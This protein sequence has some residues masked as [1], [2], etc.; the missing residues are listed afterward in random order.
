METEV[1]IS[2]QGTQ[3]DPDGGK[4]TVELLT[5]GS[6]TDDETGTYRLSYR[7]SELTGLEGT[8]T[9][10]CIGNEQ[11]AMLREG[12]LN[13][14][15]IFRTGERH[16]SLYDTDVGGFMLGVKTQYVRAEIGQ[17]GGSLELRYD[18]DVENT[19]IGRNSFHIEVKRPEQPM[20]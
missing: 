19:I 17:D 20:T 8:T 15:M 7:E 5:R 11:I 2:I 13:S 16:V 14:E 12:T 3:T 10:F 18:I 1:I 4:E 6:L 9:T